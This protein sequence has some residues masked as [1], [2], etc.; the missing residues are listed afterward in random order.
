MHKHLEI[1]FSEYDSIVFLDTETSGLDYKSDEIIELAAV[2]MLPGCVQGDEMD[3]FIKLSPGRRLDA[4]ITQLTGITDEMLLTQGVEKSE[5]CE[6]F[7]GM[8]D[9]ARPLL[10]AYNAQFDM[11]FLYWFLHRHG[12]SEILKKITMLDALTIYKDR[13]DYPHK[14][15]DAIIAYGLEDKV[16]NSHRA[17]DDTRALVEVLAA[18][19]EE[20]ADLERYINLFGYNPKYGVSG[21]KI[22]SI[23]YKAQPYGSRRKLYEDI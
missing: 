2:K 4:K 13:R 3:D 12:R 18:M 9:T 7:V 10:I 16:Q 15:A 19:G 6:R 5:A 11:N 23:S 8:L 1:L 14:I 20:C 17:I 21:A 22:S